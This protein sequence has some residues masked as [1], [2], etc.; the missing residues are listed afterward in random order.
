MQKGT[1]KHFAR[2]QEGST[3]PPK[4]MGSWDKSWTAVKG[5]CTLAV[6]CIALW[7]GTH[8]SVLGNPKAAL[9]YWNKEV[10]PRGP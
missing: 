1:Q 10:R 4:T 3:M 7:V 6:C 5:L 9:P 2:G 8:T